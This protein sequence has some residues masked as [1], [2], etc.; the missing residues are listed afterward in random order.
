MGNKEQIH[1]EGLEDSGKMEL[2]P[3]EEDLMKKYSKILLS[4]S[5]WMDNRGLEL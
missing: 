4:F 5:I 1:L 3:E 2:N